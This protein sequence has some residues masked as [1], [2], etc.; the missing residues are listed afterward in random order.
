M[1]QTKLDPLRSILQLYVNNGL[2]LWSKHLGFHKK[3]YVFNRFANY[4]SLFFSSITS[5]LNNLNCY[6]KTN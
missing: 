1:Q 4:V 5:S 6:C 3:R 2:I